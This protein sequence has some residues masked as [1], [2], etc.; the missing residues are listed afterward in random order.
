MLLLLLQQLLQL[1]HIPVFLQQQRLHLACSARCL[2]SI[3]LLL[4]LLLQQQ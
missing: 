2:V 1:L 3:L 4:L